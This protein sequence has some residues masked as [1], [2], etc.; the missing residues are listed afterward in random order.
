MF[1]IHPMLGLA[2]GFTFSFCPSLA[3]ETFLALSLLLFCHLWAFFDF[4]FRCCA[5][6]KTL[7]F[8]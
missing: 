4:P 5:P 7:S 3:S 6:G 1:M 8:F 2:L